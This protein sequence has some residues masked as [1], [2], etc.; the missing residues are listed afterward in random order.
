VWE[1]H[2]NENVL[3]NVDGITFPPFHP[4]RCFFPAE[5]RKTEDR[6]KEEE[7]TGEKK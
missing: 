7:K 4:L 2:A 5:L 3:D 6:E 1:A